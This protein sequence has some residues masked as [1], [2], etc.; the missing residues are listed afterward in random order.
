MKLD[1]GCGKKTVAGFLG[2]DVVDGPNVAFKC[3]AWHITNFVENASVEEI[4]SRHFFEHLSLIEARKTLGT[5]NKIMAPGAVAMIT[6][7][8]LKYHAEQLLTD[9]TVSEIRS[10]ISSWEHGIAGFY[11]WQKDEFDIHKMGYS[12]ES[13]KLLLEEYGFINIHEVVDKPWNLNVSFV[14]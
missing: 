12:F 8:N 14:K 10:N 13:L 9:E 4:R 7:P 3:E 11:G 2:V 6:V 5:W 1:F